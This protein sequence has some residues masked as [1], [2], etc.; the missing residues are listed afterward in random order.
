MVGYRWRAEVFE[1][2]VAAIPAELHAKREPAELFH[3]LLDHRWYLS[4]AAG[5]DVGMADAVASF[6]EQVLPEVPDERATIAHPFV[7][8]RRLAGRAGTSTPVRPSA[9]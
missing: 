9:G 2:A 3:E 7:P 4:E 5:H 6:I 1:P 8:I